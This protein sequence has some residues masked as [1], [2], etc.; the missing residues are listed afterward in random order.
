ML[1]ITQYYHPGCT[2]ISTASTITS[3]AE[4]VLKFMEIDK[5]INDGETIPNTPAIP[6]T[7]V[8][9]P[10]RIEELP[11]DYTRAKTVKS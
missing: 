8:N 6:V 9:V 2:I 1:K 10:T 7:L 4:G 3:L 11:A 5:K